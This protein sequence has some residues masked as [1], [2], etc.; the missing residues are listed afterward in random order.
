MT[1]DN[2]TRALR[3]LRFAVVNARLAGASRGKVGQTIAKAQ[4]DF[5]LVE[6]DRRKDNGE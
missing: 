2:Q 4:S 3:K 1:Y 6:K 5:A